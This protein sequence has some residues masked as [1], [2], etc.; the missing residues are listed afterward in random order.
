MD[1]KELRN[2]I[3]KHR[4]SLGLEKRKSKDN[5]ILENLFRSSLYKESNKIFTFVNYGSEVE[6]KGFIIKAIEDGKRVFVPKTIKLTKVMKAVEMK[7][8]ENLI[9]DKLGILEPENFEGEI[10]KNQLDL[11]IVPGVVFDKSGNRIGYGGGYYDRYFSDLDLTVNKVALA[12]ELQVVEYLE[13]EDHDIS[14]D[15]IITE[16]GI[17]EI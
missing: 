11:I 17:I 4:D 6:T 16:S 14:V 5:L 1:K 12:Y 2:N 3:I 15:Y 7:S 8:L 9:E 13:Y 10:Y